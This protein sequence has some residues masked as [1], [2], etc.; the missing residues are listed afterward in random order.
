M[1]RHYQKIENLE[2]YEMGDLTPENIKAIEDH[3]NTTFILRD[4]Y[5]WS[6]WHQVIIVAG[7]LV[8]RKSDGFLF[9]KSKIRLKNEGYNLL[10]TSNNN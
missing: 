3:F 4:T 1:I 9:S 7:D 5:L 8:G 2:L 6:M 10:T